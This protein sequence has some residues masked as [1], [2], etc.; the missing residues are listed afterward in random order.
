MTASWYSEHL[1]ARRVSWV[2]AAAVALL[3]ILLIVLSLLSD[4][5][6]KHLIEKTVAAKT[7]RDV[8]IEGPVHVSLWRWSPKITVDGFTLANASWAPDKPMLSLK[9]FEATVTW[10]SI[11]RFNPVFPRILIDGPNADLERDQSNRANWNFSSPGAV[12]PAPAEP[13]APLKL[14]AIQQ[15]IVSNGHL[16]ASDAIRKLKF[17]GEVS[18]AERTQNP[19]HSALKVNGAGT[20]NGKPFQLIITGGPLLQVDPGKPYA[21]DAKVTAADIKLE[22]RTEIHKAFDL[23]S[24]TSSIHLSGKDLADF[25][26]LTGLALPNT[27]PYALT[28]LVR[29]DNMKFSVDDFKG[30]LGKSDIHGKLSI[31]AGRA[32]PFLSADLT[33]SLL[34]LAD[35]ATPLGTQVSAGNKGDTL[36]APEEGGQ[37]KNPRAKPG[38]EARKAIASVDQQATET[39]FLLPDADLQVNRVRAMDADV[40]LDAESIQTEKTPIKK[41][42]FHLWLKDG[43]LKLDPLAFSLPEGEFSGQVSIDARQSVPLTEIDMRL[44]NLNLG[45]FDPKGSDTSPLEGQVI[46]RVRLTGRGSSVH[47]AASTANGDLTIV[48]PHGRMRAAFAEL[49]GIDL[50]KGL[51][52]LL[53]RKEDSTEIRC[54]VA[55]FHANNGDLKANSLLFDTTHVLVTGGGHINLQDEALAVSLRGKPKEVRVVRLRSPIEVKGTLAH[56][57]VGLE[58]GHLAAQVGAAAAL[59]AVLTPAAA[60]LAFVDGGLAKDANCSAVINQGEAQTGGS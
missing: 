33:S 2:L 48:M 24:L 8:K 7:N 19:Q 57:S 23:G 53:T 42:Q 6:W 28:G 41:V 16:R 25:Y 36:A 27:P 39:G 15:L 12:E 47:K 11:V 21:F 3:A 22:A 60:I 10:G 46:G 37:T 58:P 52:L 4:T 31:D 14:P 30:K 17:N 49:T 51:G 35:L 40:K 18:I 55:S 26:Y 56:P 45:Q 29:R 44:K 9:H 43:Q 59:G 38:K 32:R 5:M 20:L 1:I 54:G 13:S 50:D 34:N